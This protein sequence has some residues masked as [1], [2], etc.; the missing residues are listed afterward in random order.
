MTL[1]SNEFGYAVM[2]KDLKAYSFSHREVKV[3][4]EYCRGDHV[5]V[6]Q[7]PRVFGFSIRVYWARCHERISFKYNTKNIFRLHWSVS[8]EYTHKNGKI[9]S[10]INTQ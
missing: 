3:C 1:Q 8:K 2:T 4:K 5:I 6:E 10:S 9:V 7:I